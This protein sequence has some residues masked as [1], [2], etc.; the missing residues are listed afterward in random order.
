MAD[1]L[2]GGGPNSPRH[3]RTIAASLVAVA[4]VI[5]ALAVARGHNTAAPDGRQPSARF[6]S[7]STSGTST[8]GWSGFA[9]TDPP[10]APAPHTSRAGRAL[11]G[12]AVPWTLALRTPT[13]V[14]RIAMSTGLVET[15]ALPRLAST[16]PI[17]FLASKSALL[18]RPLDNVAGFRVAPGRPADPL[19]GAYDRPGMFLEGPRADELW[20][21]QRETENPQFDLLDATGRRL[22]TTGPLPNWPG[23]VSDG[24]GGVLSQL[25]TAWYDV[26]GAGGRTLV[27][28]GTLVAAGRAA[29]VIRECAASCVTTVVNRDRSS[30]RPNGF[31]HIIADV[32]GPGPLDVGPMSPDGR[33]A[34]L[35][36]R[37]SDS[38]AS[39]RIID[40]RDGSAISLPREIDLTSSGIA[41][42]AFSADS[43]WLL[44]IAA[45]HRLLA[46]DPST[47]KARPVGIRLPPVLQL[48]VLH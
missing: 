36:S 2:S 41:A 30:G 44:G 5:V 16:G 31:Q 21:E 39:L 12:A 18:V 26:D 13:S 29:Y 4:A 32:A 6:P 23:A 20:V 22:A 38:V 9:I 10:T 19:R 40:L 46:F 43:R 24:F 28:T 7:L 17:F 3:W 35:L 25:G 37:G 34:A 27:T 47:G 8:W 1:E 14:V 48:V 11:L 45:G 42:I 15:T 33:Y